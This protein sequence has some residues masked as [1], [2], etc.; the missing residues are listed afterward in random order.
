MN[1]NT[2]NIIFYSDGTRSSVEIAKLV[3]LSARY[4]RKVQL[5]HNLPRLH[6]GARLG[7]NNHQ[8]VSG[9]RIGR[10]GYVMVTVPA[11]H[12]YGRRYGHHLVK[13]YPEHRLVMEQKLGRYLLPT[14]VVDHIDGLTLHN[15]PENLRLFSSNSEHLRKT[16]SGK[17]I[18][19]S[20]RGYKNIGTRSDLGKEYQPVD[21]YSARLKSGDV[22]LRQILLAWLKLGKDSPYL[23]GT[24]H[25]LKKAGIDPSSRSTIEHA[26]AQSILKWG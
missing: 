11:E 15:A 21:T 23:L 18:R 10:D 24:T 4:V 12:P 25:H 16:V 14:E 2:Q 20:E 1:Q 6:E 8:F 3:G 17:K 13:T 19:W 7:K 26:L 9:R 22:R 5:R